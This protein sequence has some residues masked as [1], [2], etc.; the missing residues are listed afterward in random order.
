MTSTRIS[1]LTSTLTS[2]GTATS[3]AWPGSP[4]TK[5]STK[6]APNA[7]RPARRSG[8]PA[9]LIA[10]L[11]FGLAACTTPSS[12]PSNPLGSTGTV[13]NNTLPGSV[14]TSPNDDRRYRYLVLDNGL[15]TLLVSD[16]GSDK[17]AAAL[18][19]LR[20]SFD[21]PPEHPGLAHFL[22]HMLFIGTKQYPT[23]D[24]YQQF[25][26]THGGS[27]NAYTAGD[28]TNY[29]FDV[30]QDK[31]DEALDRFA[32]FFKS[33]LLDPAYVDREKNAVHSEYQLQLKDDGWRE[34]AVQKQTLNPD[35][36]GSRFNIGSLETLSGD[37]QGALIDF[38]KATYSADQMTLV[39]LGRESLDELSAMVEAKFS[40][41]PNHHIGARAALPSAIE[42]GQLPLEVRTQTVKDTR[43]L[44]FD[45]PVPSLDAHFAVK[46]GVYIANL[47]GHE[48]AGSLHHFL[49]NKG[50][51]ESL[52]AS[53]QRFDQDNAFMNVTVELTEAGTQRTAAITEALFDQIELIKAD[54]VNEWR[55]D[56]QAAL[57]ELSF[58]FRE[59]GSAIGFVNRIAP[60]LDQFPAAQIL[61]GPS[62]MQRYDGPLIR[63]Y[64][65]RL[66]PDNVIVNLSGIAVETDQVEPWFKVNYAAL[67]ASIKRDTTPNTA[68]QLPTQNPFIPQA[69]AL[70]ESAQAT[71]PTLTVKAP[72]LELWSASDVEFGTPRATTALRIA[73][74]GGNKSASDI[75]AARIYA[76]LVAD[77]LNVALYPA[78][79]A[80]LGYRIRST[81]SGF[82]IEVA[83]YSDKQVL[84]LDDLLVG[85]RELEID[86]DRF[87]LIKTELLTDWRNFKSERPYTQAWAA[88]GTLLNDQ[89]FAP[90]ALAVA[91]DPLTVARLTSWRNT[92][93]K[94][95][96]VT[97][98]V[99]G[100]IDEARTQ[101]LAQ[102]VTQRLPLAQVAAVKP[103]VTQITATQQQALTV[104]HD[105]SATV[106]YV[107][108]VDDSIN[109]QARFGLAVQMARAPYFTALR[110]EQQLG[111]VVTAA[112]NRVYKTPGL[113]FV[114]QSPVASSGDVQSATREFANGFLDTLKS[115]TP[116]EFSAAKTGYLSKL[117]EKDKNQYG[118]SQ[119]Y[120]G[121]LLFEI[122]SFDSREQVAVNVEQLTQA[123]MVAT[124]ERITQA[125]QSKFVL[126]SSPGKFAT[127]S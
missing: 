74:A 31:L 25:L 65:D 101:E 95:V 80:G 81:G 35:H 11:A 107:Q 37:I 96:G 44:S 122:E 83:G 99:H 43:K 124:W 111:Y 68:L 8:H 6:K 23:V 50:W 112:N 15:R 66:T 127:G 72:G 19:V 88:L 126:V 90:E 51:I 125:L 21:E 117:R 24:G 86:P 53:A 114:V 78:Q 36:P 59:K 93:L 29:F 110:T 100:N 1:T 26:A 54:G 27:S 46:P 52:S 48:G 16:T 18:A 71:I 9:G 20:G 82:N 106:L 87:E 120:W 32:A 56:E 118:R 30:Q 76:R 57:A 85:L 97:G 89:Q 13:A 55:Y 77:E 47:L 103:E 60:A 22:E 63:S 10:V 108:G 3:S 98:L 75:V 45:F 116:A 12:V 38:F 70:T 5:L 17:A 92:K 33:P 61:S 91:L 2:M 42:P 28:H 73:T 119:R 39:V 123:D 58:R 4:R 7:H 94:R 121:D 105:D 67:P 84:L 109:Q 64:L 79:L 41:V 14:V 69:L 113:A 34:F 115:M 62:L 40:A 102:L 104:D 49:R